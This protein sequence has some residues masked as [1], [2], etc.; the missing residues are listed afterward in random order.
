LPGNARLSFRSWFQEFHG[1]SIHVFHVVKAQRR[2]PQSGSDQI[3]W[4]ALLVPTTDANTVSHHPSKSSVS[5]QKPRFLTTPKTI[6]VI[7]QNTQTPPLAF[8][9]AAEVA[10]PKLRSTLGS[11]F[12]H[13]LIYDA[14]VVY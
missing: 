8:F 14:L 10:K 6:F 13:F 5:R 1:F 2:L 9:V 4:D 7:A 11:L 3:A 12:R